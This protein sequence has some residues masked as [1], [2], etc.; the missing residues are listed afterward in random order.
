[1][2]EQN[3]NHT[4][5][6]KKMKELAESIDFTM[7]ATNLSEHPIHA[8][9]MST[10]KVDGDGA[11]WFLSGRDS[12]HNANIKKTDQVQLFYSKP[13]NMEFM[14]VSGTATITTDRTI[15]ENLYSKSDDM[16]FDGLDDPNL[17]AIKVEPT[18]GQYWDS[19]HSNLISFFK[20]GVAAISGEQPDISEHGNLEV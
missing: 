17:T 11:I 14:T 3:L 2:S 1:M 4:D 9:P 20:M 19:K 5:A 16:W 8:I 6:I 18:N 13:S 12:E 15:L 7:M 10:K